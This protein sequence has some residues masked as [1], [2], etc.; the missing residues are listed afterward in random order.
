[1][2]AK[3]TLYERGTNLPVINSLINKHVVFFS[4]LGN[5]EENYWKCW[6]GLIYLLD[7]LIN[8]GIVFLVNG[9]RFSPKKKIAH[10][11]LVAPCIPHVSPFLEKPISCYGSVIPSEKITALSNIMSIASPL[12]VKFYHN[13]WTCRFNLDDIHDI[14]IWIKMND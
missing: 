2:S 3:M 6:R 14:R 9:I 5:G 4:K 12:W 7:E 8:S 13:C 11:V 10:V 1:M